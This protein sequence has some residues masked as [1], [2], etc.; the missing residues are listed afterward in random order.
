M[1]DEQVY[2]EQ[3]FQEYKSYFESQGT[4]IVDFVQ[5]INDIIQHENLQT[6][7]V[8]LLNELERINPSMT[9]KE[10]RIF[11]KDYPSHMQIEIYIYLKFLLLENEK[12]DNFIKLSKCIAFV[13]NLLISKRS[14]LK[15]AELILFLKYFY[16]FMNCDEL[17][18]FMDITNTYGQY[19]SLD[20]SKMNNML[21]KKE[22]YISPS[23]FCYFV[24]FSNLYNRSRLLYKLIY[25]LSNE[26]I[27]INAVEDFVLRFHEQCIDKFVIMSNFIECVYPR[28]YDLNLNYKDVSRFSCIEEE[29]YILSNIPTDRK[30]KY[31]CNYYWIS[32]YS[33]ENYSISVKVFEN[34]KEKETYVRSFLSNRLLLFEHNYPYVALAVCLEKVFGINVDENLLNLVYNNKKEREIISNSYFNQKNKIEKIQKIKKL[35]ENY[36]TNDIF[37]EF[38]QTV[39]HSK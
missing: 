5:D 13:D 12:K 20:T 16:K 32:K 33:H 22:E 2:N 37:K 17:T 23:I 26:T 4:N 36:I 10:L 38:L 7:L 31:M 27:Y 34:Q 19:I 39:I 15:E 24:K 25:L 18:D 28:H 3:D 11:Q 9:T 1:S 29:Q 8:S 21:Y 35:E 6:D 30:L 14:D